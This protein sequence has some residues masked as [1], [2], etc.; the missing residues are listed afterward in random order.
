MTTFDEVVKDFLAQKRIAV[1]GVSRHSGQ[2]ANFIFKKLR[3]AGYEVFPVNPHATEV[4]GA[5]CFPNLQSIPGGVTAVVVVTAP[6][7]A[8]A[9]VRECADLGIHRVWLHRSFGQGS[10]SD[11]AMRLGRERGLTVIPAGCPA[12]FC[13]PIDIG[14]KCFR[15]ILHLTGRLPQQIALPS[16][17]DTS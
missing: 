12:M 4:E 1:A 16:G 17:P 10:F 11:T 13:A 6:R 9:V 15:W 2:A 7:A 8:E 3:K 14:H 5:A